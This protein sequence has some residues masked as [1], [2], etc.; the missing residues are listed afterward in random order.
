MTSWTRLKTGSPLTAKEQ[1]GK[2]RNSFQPN[3][4]RGF[5]SLEAPMKA[6]TPKHQ[7]AG[8]NWQLTEFTAFSAGS[9]WEQRQLHNGWTSH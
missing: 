4:F 2:P 3:G 8:G 9:L 5:Y 1:A 7:L 6:I